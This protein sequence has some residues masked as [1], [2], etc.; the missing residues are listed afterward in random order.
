MCNVYR[1]NLIDK[2]SHNSKSLLVVAKDIPDVVLESKLVLNAVTSGY[3]V[4]NIESINTI[5]EQ[6]EILES[7]NVPDQ[8]PS[9]R[10]AVVVAKVTDQPKRRR[11]S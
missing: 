4:V 1:V 5:E 7:T 9:P 10:K 11:K 3:V 2:K 6:I 8:K